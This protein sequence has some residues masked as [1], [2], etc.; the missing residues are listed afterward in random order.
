M[1]DRFVTFVTNHEPAMNISRMKLSFHLT[2]SLFLFLSACYTQRPL[3]TALPVQAS[4]IIAR[5]T[6]SGTVAMANAIGPGADVVEGVVSSADATTWNLSVMR[7]DYRGGSSVN[8]NHEVVSFPRYALT[9]VSEKKLDRTKSWLAG[10]IIAVT[11]FAAAKLFGALGA[12][13]NKNPGPP[14]PN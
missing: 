9:G 12:D 2:A 7:V 8:W 4:T 5:V 13:E 14:P 3:Q 1:P 11:A 10:G 6:D